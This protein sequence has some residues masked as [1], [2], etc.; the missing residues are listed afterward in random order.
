MNKRNAHQPLIILLVLGLVILTGSCKKDKEDDPKT[1]TELLT[2]GSWKFTAF[3]VDP[4]YPIFDDQ[5]NIIGTSDDVLGNMDDCSV[6][7]I[8]SFKTDNT[9]TFD[10]GA[11]KCDPADPQTISGTWL[12][13]TDETVLSITQDGY[14]QDN[15]ILELTESV[16]KVKYTEVSASTNYTYTLT[17]S[18]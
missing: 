2:T 16:L 11:T 8:H 17:F 15:I 6:N 9:F 13:K 14:T 12:F 4:P 1:K 18:H 5:G 3:T 10:E 7:D